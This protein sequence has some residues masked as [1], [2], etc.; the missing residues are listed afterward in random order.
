VAGAL[1]TAFTGSAA[2]A[3]GEVVEP[4]R[5]RGPVLAR[6]ESGAA[7]FRS[8]ASG[9]VA[10]EGGRW[11]T[12]FP[13][14]ADLVLPKGQSHQDRPRARRLVP[15]RS[16]P[17]PSGADDVE[18]RTD[19]G[20]AVSSWLVPPGDAG[21]VEPVAGLLPVDAMTDYLADALD[22][23]ID[24]RALGWVTSSPQEA[25]L[26]GE[27]RVGLARKDRTARD[28]YLYATT[29]QRPREGWGF[30]AECVDGPATVGVDPVGPVPLGGR[31]RLADVEIVDAAWPDPPDDYPQ[32]QVLLY[33]A[34]PAVWEGGWR[35]P[36]PQG[37]RL[38]GACVPDPVPVSVA[39]VRRAPR[40]R[41]LLPTVVLRWAVPAGAVYL[42]QF[43]DRASGSSGQG[44]DG[45]QWARR[46]AQAVH[47]QA[48]G[49]AQH[50]GGGSAVDGPGSAGTDRTATAGFGVVLTGRWG[51]G[52][53]R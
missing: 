44:R 16:W 3:E 22:R 47:A 45:S 51:T 53:D 5:V 7:A 37:V 36:L 19:L 33:V 39:S 8:A 1:T 11:V 23:W 21:A 6:R 28:G 32:G 14:P 17:G 24:L 41:R 31:S 25:P 27:P 29:H 30:L 35:P 20:E 48:L 40:R 50:P 46:W 26:V 42:L 43:P 2:F 13:V 18:V 34:T 52:A 12:H 38:V 15:L 49:P 10:A 9:A 4:D